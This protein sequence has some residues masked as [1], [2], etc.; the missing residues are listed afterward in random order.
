VLHLL[1]TL[2]IGLIVGFVAK[3]LM[4]GKNPT[5]FFIT[6]CIGIAGSF[7]ATWI[8]NMIGYHAGTPAGF[9]RSVLGAML[10]LFVYHLIFNRRS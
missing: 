5:G 4:P 10:L 6:I 1:W 3:L 9:I 8:G 7:I 2:I